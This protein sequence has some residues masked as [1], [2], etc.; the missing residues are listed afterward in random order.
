MTK[1][2]AAAA[3]C[4]AVFSLASTASAY[5]ENPSGKCLIH[6]E[7]TFGP[8]NLGPL[9]KA[10]LGYTFVG[11]AECEMLP[12][13]EIRKGTVEVR[14]EETLSCFGSLGEAEG[15]G[16]LTL[17]GINFTFGLT[18]MS[19]AP[20]STGLVAKFGDGGVAVGTA[21]F[22]LSAIEPATSCFSNEGSS[23]L[24]FKAVATGTL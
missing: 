18:F 5:A 9:P 11:S 23:V 17:A 1:L 4:A 14:G 15:K 24:E 19:G 7:A 10:K 21:T 6:G 22:L 8:G 13:R 2:T 16:T 20:G 12:A 3:I